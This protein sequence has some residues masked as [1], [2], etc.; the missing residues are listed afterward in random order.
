MIGGPFEPD[1]SPTYGFEDFC[2]LVTCNAC[3]RQF[4]TVD[5]WEDDDCPHCD[6]TRPGDME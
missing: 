4:W 3:G 6:A 1:G 5:R 2:D